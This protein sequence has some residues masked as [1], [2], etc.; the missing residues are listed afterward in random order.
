MPDRVRILA[1]MRRA[2]D[3]C[4]RPWTRSRPEPAAASH[5]HGGLRRV[6]PG[7]PRHAGPGEHITM[8]VIRGRVLRVAVRDGNP[9]WQP[10]LL[11]NGFGARLELL[12]PFVDALDPPAAHAHATP[13]PGS[14]LPG[15]DRR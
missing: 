3:M 5:R 6:G 8:P 11:C 14:R 4:M 2:R 12:Q 9:A 1:V 13:P 10:L 15:P 7:Q